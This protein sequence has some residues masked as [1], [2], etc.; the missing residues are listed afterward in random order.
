MGSRQRTERLSSLSL[1]FLK[2]TFYLLYIGAQ[3][4]NNAVVVS[5]AKQRASATPPS[6][7]GPAEESTVLVPR[8]R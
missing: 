3:P 4:I 6:Y 2:T 8:T 5:G 7:L 1:Y